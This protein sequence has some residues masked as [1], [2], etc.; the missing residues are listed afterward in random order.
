MTTADPAKGRY[1]ALM[2]LRIMAT[3]MIVGGIILA[4]GERQWLE[5]ETQ[6]M[7]GYGLMAVG[8]FDQSHFHHGFR[9]AF[10]LTPAEFRA[11][12]Q[13]FTSRAPR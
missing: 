11:Q 3:V 8:F 6:R 13:S 9:Q 7:L 2:A 10:G 5:P 4:F 12:M 1:I